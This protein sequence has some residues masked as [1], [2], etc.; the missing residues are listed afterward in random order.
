MHEFWIFLTPSY[1]FVTLAQPFNGP[2]SG[3]ARV[4]AGTRRNI[5]PLSPIPTIKHPSPISSIHY[6][7]QYP[8]VE[9]TAW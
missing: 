9:S 6:D 7:P 4:Y 1:Q 3:T 8:P 5:H 2:L